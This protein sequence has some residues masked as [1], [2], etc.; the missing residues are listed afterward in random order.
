MTTFSFLLPLLL[1]SPNCPRPCHWMHW[2]MP[3][4]VLAGLSNSQTPEDEAETETE[5]PYNLHSFRT[6]VTQL[7][8][9]E[10]YKSF[11]RVGRSA[12]GINANPENPRKWWEKI[13][14][15]IKSILLMH[16][17]HLNSCNNH[18]TTWWRTESR[19]NFLDQN[20]GYPF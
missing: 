7:K 12:G 6:I 1:K 17:I 9:Q 11:R 5:N 4:F 14:I 8:Y 10:E 16:F 20:T 3:P 19:H 13:L 2:S 15:L 18:D